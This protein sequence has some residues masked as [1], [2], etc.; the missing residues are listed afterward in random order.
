[1]MK[2]RKDRANREMLNVH[3][4]E[5]PGRKHQRK[6]RNADEMG[7]ASTASFCRKDACGP[8]VSGKRKAASTARCVF[9]HLAGLR[10]LANPYRPPDLSEDS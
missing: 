6:H 1:M 8:R 2:E 9:R 3:N 10:L 5:V 4:V 7:S